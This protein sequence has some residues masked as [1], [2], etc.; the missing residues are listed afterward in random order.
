M[1]DS[2]PLAALQ[3]NLGVTDL[4]NG[5]PVVGF[6]L[7]ATMACTLAHLAP[8]DGSVIHRDGSPARLGTSILVMGSGSSGRI[9]D[10][11]IAE[12]GR[13]QNNVVS[14]IE[15][16][17]KWNEAA[18]SNKEISRL[19]F[20]KEMDSSVALISET[21]SEFGDMLK[22][23]QESWQKV[24]EQT[25]HQSIN[26]IGKHPKFLVSV[27][28]KKSIEPQLDRLRPGSPLVHLGLSHPDDLIRHSETISALLNGHYPLD[29][30]VRTI[31]GNFLI[32]DPMQVLIDAARNPDER[33]RWLGQL[34]WLTDCDAGP[35]APDQ[36]EGAPSP[37]EIRIE[38]HFRQ[39]LSH[40]MTYRLNL[41]NMAPLV[42]PQI[43]YATKLRWTNFLKEMEPRLPGISGA[44]RNLLTTL[45][46]GLELMTP[47]PNGLTI[48]GLEAFA[49]FLVRR[50]ANARISILHAGELARRRDQIFRV[51]TKL[52]SGPL[53]ERKICRDLKITAADRDGAL[54]WL[55]EANLVR[56]TTGNTWERCGDAHLSFKDCSIPILEV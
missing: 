26:K 12:I 53:H 9:V 34:L 1:D 42:A 40:V 7:L 19:D 6:N 17:F 36:P 20:K 38:R 3:R 11:I 44:A 43:P 24:L 22:G 51:F 47:R 18:R 2:A 54:R 8:D 56:P 29:D 27:G 4:G 30:G 28:G 41:P 55:E 16:Y 15:S 21:Q 35:D 50:M 5:D 37:S 39:A 48:S 32:T 33:T 10:E 45:A 14:H 25:P 49:R 23:H 13:R 31:K 52:G 46:F